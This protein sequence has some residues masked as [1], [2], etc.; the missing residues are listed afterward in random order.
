MLAPPVVFLCVFLVMPLA[1]VMWASIGPPEAPFSV[2]ARVVAQGFYLRS[3]LYTV[4]T[5]FVVTLVCLA[6]AYPLAYAVANARGWTGRLMSTAILLPLWTSVVI[7]SYAW[8]IL[9]QRHGPVNDGLL[10]LH[11]IAEPV[12]ILQTSVAVRIGMV[13]ILLP[14]MVLP[15]IA[16]MSKV[17]RTL[18]RAAS[19]LGATPMRVFLRVYLRLTLPGVLAGCS[20]V[21]ISALGFY[22][23]P[24]LLGGA[25]NAT[26]AMM[27]E[28]AVSVFLDWPLASAL[29]TILLLTTVALYLAFA[30]LTGG[31]LGTLVR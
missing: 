3:F 21:F 28:Q 9:F 30:R 18:L 10:W 27:I 1:R 6:T 29:S 25:R 23:T 19:V 13:H 20:L 5:A 31:E 16:S 14:F 17:D 7:R 8:L 2:Y 12:Q 24:A 11:W 26:A 4:E 22:I 15:L